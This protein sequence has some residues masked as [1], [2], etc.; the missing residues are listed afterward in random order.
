MKI[1]V[2]YMQTAIDN[3]VNYGCP[4]PSEMGS[5]F[6]ALL[7]HDLMAAAMFADDNNRP[8]LADWAMYLYN[9][10]PAPAHGSAPVLEAWHLKGG[11]LGRQTEVA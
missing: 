4:H 6:R 3:W 8:K 5:F 7:Q 10:V 2:E 1:P 9:E 11:L